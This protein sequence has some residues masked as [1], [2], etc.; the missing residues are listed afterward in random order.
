MKTEAKKIK[1]LKI[2]E[3]LRQNSDETHP[4]TTT[5]MINML[6]NDGIE[7]T[8][9][10]VYSD[11]K[12]LNDYGY[13]IICLRRTVNEYFIDDGSFELPEI[14][15]LMDAVQ[16]ASFIT[17]KKTAVLIDKVAA[18]GG[19]YKGEILKDNI[20][21]FNTAK[22][23]NEQ[24]YY[25][26]NELTHAI[27]NKKKVTF[28]YFDFNV[29]KQKVYRKDGGLY[30]ENPYSLVYSDDNYYLVTFNE[31]FGNI[32]HYRIDRMETVQTVDE[33]SNFPDGFN[34]EKHKSEV[35][36]M[37]VGDKYKVRI[38]ARKYLIDTILDKFGEDIKLYSFSDDEI[39]F[40]A[41]VQVSARFIS[42][43]CSF[44]DSMRVISP[45]PVIEQIKDYLKTVAKQYE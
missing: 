25:N 45:Q 36:G 31:T 7:A 6:A 9:Q 5:E 3:I 20:V 35:F 4:I 14:R 37:F 24:I 21:T 40:D 22:H 39:M 13:N 8:R 34:L 42:W 28:K 2:L 44:G 19:S 16:A 10:T 12:T 23:T 18:L 15:I 32:T 33:D 41:E 38:H 11:I 1:I 30:K 29:N 27:Q 17:P 43:V 26:I